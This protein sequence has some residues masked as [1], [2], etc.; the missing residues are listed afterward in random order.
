VDV[1]IINPN[2]NHMK[3]KRCLPELS[4]GSMADIAFLLLTFYMMTT[5]IQDNKGLALLLP[6]FQN[7]PMD[8]PIPSKNLFTIQINS[9][10]QLMIEGEFV[11]SLDGL[12]NEI[13][14]FILNNG[15]DKLS[16]ASPDKAVVS[17]KT[18]RGT[19]YQSFLHALDEAQAAYYEIYGSRSGISSTEFRKLNLNNPTDKTIYEKARKGIPMNISIAEPTAVAK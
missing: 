14:D 8:Q 15:K 19:S 6:P 1:V 12:R 13:K 3:S 16:S 2:N 10:D 7:T 18:D 5:V 11:Q 9:Q 4:S 17:I